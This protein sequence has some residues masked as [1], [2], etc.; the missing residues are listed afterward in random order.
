MQS[1]ISGISNPV[2]T[3]SDICP[4]YT[5]RNEQ[6]NYT[7][8]EWYK[9]QIKDKSISNPNW[10]IHQRWN[11][12]KHTQYYEQS[13]LNKY[14]NNLK[15][16]RAK[17]YIPPR[18]PPTTAQYQKKVAKKVAAVLY[19]YNY[20]NN[21]DILYNILDMISNMGYAPE[22]IKKFNIGSCVGS[23]ISIHDALEYFAMDIDAL[24]LKQKHIILTSLICIDM[25]KVKDDDTVFKREV[26]KNSGLLR[27]INRS[28][29]H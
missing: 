10:S 29:K 21:T 24:T 5:G 11:W 27:T 14:W 13:T 7:I 23:I 16:N 1:D 18:S 12:F 26:V 9:K 8:E 3:A 4:T 17:R 25:N 28:T 2:Y 6:A 19:E 15:K 22:E 20:E